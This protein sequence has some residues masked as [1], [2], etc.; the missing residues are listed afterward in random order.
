MLCEKCVLLVN[1]LNNKK[2]GIK[3]NKI[4]YSSGNGVIQTNP[5]KMLDME[6]QFVSSY[7]KNSGYKSK[8]NNGCCKECCNDDELIDEEDEDG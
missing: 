3:I 7:F 6:E 2:Y 4:F 8:L 5:S 1:N